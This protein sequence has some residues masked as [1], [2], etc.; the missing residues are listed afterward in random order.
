MLSL[1]GGVDRGFLL[2]ALTGGLV[3]LALTAGRPP[4]PVTPAPVPAG[5]GSSRTP[6]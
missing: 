1:T 5:T 3:Y 2:S 4:V 6:V